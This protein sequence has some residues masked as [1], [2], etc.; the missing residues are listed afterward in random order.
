MYYHKKKHIQHLNSQ[1]IH[2]YSIVIYTL[3]KNTLLRSVCHQIRLT[4]IILI[5]GQLPNAFFNLVG[6]FL[7]LFESK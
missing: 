2:I 4:I 7:I 3:C 6:L 5:L 1:S